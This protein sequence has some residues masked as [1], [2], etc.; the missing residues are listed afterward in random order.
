MV[1]TRSGVAVVHSATSYG[2][3]SREESR[4]QRMKRK[5]N[6]Q[7]D[8]GVEGAGTPRRKATRAHAQLLESLS[9]PPNAVSGLVVARTPV[10]T[11]SPRT[12]RPLHDGRRRPR[13][14]DYGPSRHLTFQGQGFFFC[15]KCDLWDSL[16]PDGR[17]RISA[18]SSTYRCTANHQNFSYPTALRPD[19]SRRLLPPGTDDREDDDAASDDDASDY[20]SSL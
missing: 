2:R 5:A 11:T 6:L 1:R 13:C 10:E 20:D 9:T 16:P 14:S 3:A 12:L 7:T 18:S 15:H 8:T 17:K 19:Y 4:R